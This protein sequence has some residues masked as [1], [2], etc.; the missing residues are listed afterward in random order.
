MRKKNNGKKYHT[1]ILEKMQYLLEIWY[2]Q[3]SS[4]K[5]WSKN[6]FNFFCIF[7]LL[8]RRINHKTSFIFIKRLIFALPCHVSLRSTLQRQYHIILLCYEN[9]EKIESATAGRFNYAFLQ[10]KSNNIDDEV[11]VI[12]IL[13]EK[14]IKYCDG[15]QCKGI[16]RK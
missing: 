1:P 7:V 9:T 10:W 16:L 15:I 4:V 5:F 8:S 13:M 3:I 6:L 11:N 14:K 2:Y 12:S